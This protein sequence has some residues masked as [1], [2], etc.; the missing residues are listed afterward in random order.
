MKLNDDLI[1]DLL[2]YHRKEKQIEAFMSILYDL[3]SVTK[4]L[5]RDSAT[6]VEFR[7]IFD[8]VIQKLT[9]LRKRLASNAD[10]VREPYFESGVVNISQRGHN[11]MKLM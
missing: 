2:Q 1:S 11:T 5:K 9:C 4:S 3:E 8:M 10:I 6:M 7:D